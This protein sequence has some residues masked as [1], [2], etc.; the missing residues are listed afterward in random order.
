MISTDERSGQLLWS[1]K[2]ER[3]PLHVKLTGAGELLTFT[4]FG[5]LSDFDEEKISLVAGVAGSGLWDLTLRFSSEGAHI[6]SAASPDTADGVVMIDSGS[7]LFKCALYR[8]K[9]RF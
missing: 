6:T 3:T 9:P 7:G 4:G 5:T 8:R 2:A 1:W